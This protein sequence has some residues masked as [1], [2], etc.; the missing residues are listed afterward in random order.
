M[1][2]YSIFMAKLKIGIT[3]SSGGARGIARDFVIEPTGVYEYGVFEFD[4]ADELFRH[5]YLSTEKKIPELFDY[6][7]LDKIMERKKQ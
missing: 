3:L 4:K 5:G 2:D 6:F 7:N 1:Y